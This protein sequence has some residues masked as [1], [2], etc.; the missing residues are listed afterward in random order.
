MADLRVDR[1]REV[2]RR[3]AR[4]QRDHA[5]LRREDEHLVLF[6]VDLQALHELAGIGGVLLPVD[7]ALE[8]H[9]IL[10]RVV[11]LLVREVRGDAVLGPAV[12]LVGTDL[13]LDRAA[14]GPHHR[15]VQR[16][17][18]V[19]LGHRDVVLEP[20]LHRP[21]Q[22]VDRAQRAVTVLDRV[23]DHAHA[24][25]VVDLVELLAPHDHLLVDRPVVL[26]PAAHVGADLELI[27]TGPHLL[28][29]LVEVGLALAGRVQHH[30]LD[31]DVALRV[32]HCEREIL[33]LPLHVLH[34]EPVREGA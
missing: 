25:E 1:V 26:R 28:E 27:E 16:L 31:L 33:E 19:E 29:H 20:T 17:V 34:T 4:R 15:R 12:H 10:G 14:L 21:P 3:R 22:R 9:Q 5:A 8:P 24:D 32:Q 7:D 23:D 30:R 13:E 18:E 2:D 11:L 6:E